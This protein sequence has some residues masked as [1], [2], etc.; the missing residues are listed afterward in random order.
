[1]GTDSGPF[2]LSL[3][4][5]YQKSGLIWGG[6]SGSKAWARSWMKIMSSPPFTHLIH[7]TRK[8]QERELPGK[9]YKSLSCQ[10]SL[11][12]HFPQ[13]II[14]KISSSTKKNSFLKKNALIQIPNEA[15]HGKISQASHLIKPWECFNYL[16]HYYRIYN[17]RCEHFCNEWKLFFLHLSNGLIGLIFYR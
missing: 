2:F 5:I 10:L 16:C 6:T 9:D 13:Q 17:E 4:L 8:S 11:R 15:T 1:M 7:L 14:T 12:N 3:E